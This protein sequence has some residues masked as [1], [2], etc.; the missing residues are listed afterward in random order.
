M[1][2]VTPGSVADFA[3]LSVSPW[4]VPDGDISD[5]TVS[6]TVSDGEVVFDS[7]D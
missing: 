6:L 2:T 4:D 5:I 1:G 3:V 7:G